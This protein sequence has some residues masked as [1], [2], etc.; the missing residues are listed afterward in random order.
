MNA[1]K[2]HANV[3]TQYQS[4]ALRKLY[5]R[6]RAYIIH[7]TKYTEVKEFLETTLRE[8][9]IETN[10]IHFLGRASS[11]PINLVFCVET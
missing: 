3:S 2:T 8:L 9:T 6:L 10:G 1:N 5:I 4:K 11:V 7:N